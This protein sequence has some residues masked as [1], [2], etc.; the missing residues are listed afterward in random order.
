MKYKNPLRYKISS[1]KQLPNC[2]SNNDKGFKIHVAEY[3]Q[4]TDLKG[5]RISVTHPEYGVVFTEILGAKGSYITT[6]EDLDTDSPIAFELK[7]DDILQE[8]RKFGFFITYN[9]VEHLPVKILE[10]LDTVKDLDFDK[11]RV[12]NVWDRNKAGEQF[13]KWYVV[14]F[15][16]CKHVYWLNN[17]Y[18][19]SKKEFT[20]ALID[21]T[22][23][24]ISDMSSAQ[25]FNWSWLDFV[26]NIEDILKDNIG[27]DTYGS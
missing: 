17:N 18:S 3:M 1:W 15:Q 25:G 13:F 8:L 22:A 27:D 20:D 16:S 10:Y 21:G 2:L 23:I 7:P 26:A 24:N 19:P 4:N 6:L 14:V 5:T 11:L 9:P 12:L